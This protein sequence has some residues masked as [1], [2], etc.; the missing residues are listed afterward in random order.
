[1]CEGREMGWECY[2]KTMK[3]GCTEKARREARLA[4]NQRRG[5]TGDARNG[6]PIEERRAEDARR[7][8]GVRFLV[9]IDARRMHRVKYRVPNGARKMHEG[10]T[11]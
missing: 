1:M 5:C 2:H 9:P 11:E 10:C 7:M 6:N 3:G 4:L 8:H